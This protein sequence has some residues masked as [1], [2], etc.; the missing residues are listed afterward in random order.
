MVLLDEYNDPPWP[1]C[2]KAVD[3]FLIGKQETL[4][5]IERDYYQKWFFV[6]RSQERDTGEEGVAVSGNSGSLG[7][8]RFAVDTSD[9]CVFRFSIPV[10]RFNGDT[11][12]R[13][14]RVLK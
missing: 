14:G 6:K 5:I 3:E 10:V 8:H 13:D 7:S 2:N 4:E 1:G 12:F 9:R 11:Q